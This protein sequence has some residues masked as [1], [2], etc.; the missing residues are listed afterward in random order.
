MQEKEREDPHIH[1]IIIIINKQH[2][3]ITCKYGINFSRK[4]KV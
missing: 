1:I 3:C 4:S 2:L